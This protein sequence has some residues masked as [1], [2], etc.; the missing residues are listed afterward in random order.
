MG[1]TNH[2]PRRRPMRQ[3]ID[4]DDDA[5]DKTFACLISKPDK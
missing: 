2:N 1:G 5:A 4:N 3:A